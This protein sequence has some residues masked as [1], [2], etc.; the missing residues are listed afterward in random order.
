MNYFKSDTALLKNVKIGDNSK[1]WHY[2]NLFD[3]ELGENTTVGAFCEIQ[4]DVSI[5]SNVTISSHCFICSLVTI[6]DS[7]FIGHGVMTIN[8][9]YP[10][11]FRRT[12]KRDQWKST[13]IKKGAVIGSNSTLL[14]VIIG[15]NSIVAAGSVVTKDVPANTI[16]GGNPAKII[17]KK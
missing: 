9:L 7:V 10:P 12:G 17:R 15:E 8:D 13:H 6:E 2:S 1:I 11:S 14:P 3:C 5:G 16:V 4:G